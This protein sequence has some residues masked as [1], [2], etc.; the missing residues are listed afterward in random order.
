MGEEVEGILV[1][2]GATTYN[3]NNAVAIGSCSAGSDRI[4]FCKRAD[5]LRDAGF[6]GQRIKFYLIMGP[7]LQYKNIQI[8]GDKPLSELKTSMGASEFYIY[9]VQIPEVDKD[10]FVDLQFVN[11]AWCW[12]KTGKS[13]YG[14]NK[15]FCENIVN[16]IRKKINKKIEDEFSSSCRRSCFEDPVTCPEECCPTFMNIVDS[17]EQAT[18]YERTFLPRFYDVYKQTG[19]ILSCDDDILNRFLARMEVAG[20]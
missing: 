9:S 8:V 16:E 7:S 17:E 15:P 18:A 13:E 14:A 4:S 6:T 19:K 11:D 3:E 1:K 2:E 12:A 20:G 5:Y 10:G